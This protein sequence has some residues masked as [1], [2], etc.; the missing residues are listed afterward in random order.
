MKVMNLLQA[1]FPC[2]ITG[3]WRF[4]GGELLNEVVYCTEH[5]VFLFDLQSLGLL[6]AREAS[7]LV[8]GAFSGLNSPCVFDT[9]TTAGS[10]AG[11]ATVS[12]PVTVGTDPAEQ[13]LRYD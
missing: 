11:H 4:I 12:P 10:W 13:H 3:L 9:A 6:R 8:I 7:R 2:R 5:I 1:G